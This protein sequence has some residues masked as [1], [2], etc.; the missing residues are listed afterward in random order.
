MTEQVG[1]KIVA[2]AKGVT[3]GVEEAKAAVESLTPAVEGISAKFKALGATISESMSHATES[4]RTT[5]EMMV[6][7]REHVAVLAEAM[8]AA[9]AVERIAEFAI[10]MGEAAEK[11][12]HLAQTF[13][14][15]IAQVQQLG[16]VAAASGKG[17]D[18]IVRALG[19]MDKNLATSAGS[20]SAQ[21]AAFKFLGISINDGR[22]QMEKMLVAA[23]KFKGMADGPEKV[24]LAMTAFGKSGKDMINVLDLGRA[25]LEALNAK[26]AEYGGINEV[27][28]QKGMALAE[29]V[30]E[31]SIAML[32]VNNVM[33]DGFAP[34][35]KEVT[36]DMNS[37]IKAFIQSYDSGGTVNTI[38]TVIADTFKA[39]VT[40]VEALGEVFSTVWT[41]MTT[42]VGEVV[43]AFTDGVGVKMPSA[44]TILRYS[45]ALVV[46]SIVMVKDAVLGLV[47]IATGGA[48]VIIRAW[49]MLSN[50]L[51]DFPSWTAIKADW[52]AG[53]ADM[54]ASVAKTTA[55]VKGYAAEMQAALSGVFT[56][57][58][59]GGSE[60]GVEAGHEGAGDGA[61]ADL[62]HH[63]KAPK[64]KDDVVQK[65][66]EELEAKKLAWDM[67]NDA[68]DTAQ[69]Y[70]LASEKEFWAAALAQTNL[71]AKDRSEI[72]AKYLAVSGK[73]RAQDIQGIIDGYKIQL[74][75]AKGSAAAQE[76]IVK[77]EAAFV[78][79][80]Y[81]AESS[82]YK[83]MQVA[84]AAAA[85]KT[86]DEGKQLA[87]QN[88]QETLKAQKDILS[89]AEDAGKFR[90]EMGVE[91]QAK[92]IAQER[93]FEAKKNEID[94]AALTQAWNAAAGDKL[95][96]NQLYN[97][98]L[99]L[100][101][102]YQ[103]KKTQLE[104]AAVL[105]RTLIERQAVTSISSSWAQAFSRL[106]TLQ[107]SFAGT[108]KS[109]WQGV[110]Q[111]I[112]N[113]ISGMLETV[114]QKTI[115][116]LLG[117]KVAQTAAN[118]ATVASN[119]AVAGAG[120]VASMAAAPWPLDM[121]APA[122]GAAMSAAAM[123]FAPAAS[124][125]GGWWEVPSDTV[126]QLHAN[127][128]VLPA[129]LA[130]PLRSVIGQAA[131]NNHPA[132]AGDG[133]GGGDFHYHDHSGN[134]TPAQIMSNRDAVVKAM[135]QAQ[136][137]GKFAGLPYRR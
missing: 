136:R 84:M 58:V 108:L 101:R 105:Q 99:D 73:L 6:T 15:S 131:N 5:G 113:A 107:T 122:F 79:T 119:A 25:G 110:Q 100:D 112:G 59:V 93:D 87:A 75:A 78:L 121:G 89:D 90:V 16:G 8:I 42:I 126:T 96:Q 69:Q 94:K 82:E 83:A 68:Q 39:F 32:G 31:S 125:A 45:L 71:S 48:D 36:D 13:G 9:F 102:Q 51:S 47:A 92:L 124:A 109:L 2:D 74:D 52:D 118:T 22:S 116:N 76:A 98:L 130:T 104:R 128:M 63:A 137:E 57:T 53:T 64:A 4:I 3:P 129:H 46:D 21:A 88:A 91:T 81:G 97:Q 49:K 41:A 35:L 70:S 103:L 17:V 114:L 56:G 55:K 29:S 132:G 111:A 26:T 14:M 34:I 44:A 86:A 12:V 23:D 50:I 43:G 127:E 38:V 54:A 117:I 115:T 37:M 11:T 95:K 19:I 7:M 18:T 85:K 27:A 28:A 134:L 80:K 77:D 123:A 40:V 72:E 135:V 24:A 10:H 61:G 33:T 1:V 65:L 133:Q 60:G 120:G 106:V 30:N 67:Q 20:T 62:G 66:Q